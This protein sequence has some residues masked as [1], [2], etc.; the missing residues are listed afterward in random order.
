MPISDE[1]VLIMLHGGPGVGKTFTVNLTAEYTRRPLISISMADIFKTGQDGP[2]RVRAILKMASHW[3]ALVSLENVELLSE[4][5]DKQDS[6][7]HANVLSI[8]QILERHHGLVFLIT[9]RIGAVNMNLIT[10]TALA[11]N[12]PPL[13]ESSQIKIL[14]SLAASHDGIA[15]KGIQDAASEWRLWKTKGMNGWQIQQGVTAALELSRNEETP[16]DLWLLEKTFSSQV[17]LQSYLWTLG[18][19]DSDAALKRNHR[20]DSFVVVSDPLVRFKGSK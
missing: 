10:R 5:E 7:Q 19:G 16:F 11:I 8:I 13:D 18:R 20:N 9:D 12:L 3:N 17:Q 14:H 15:R 4:D 1:S 2:R 6:P